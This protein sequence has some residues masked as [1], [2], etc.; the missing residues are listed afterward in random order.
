MGPRSESVLFWLFS[1][2]LLLPT[3]LSRHHAPPSLRTTTLLKDFSSNNIFL[4][5]FTKLTHI[6][7]FIT[8]LDGREIIRKMAVCPS[9]PVA[10]INVITVDAIK[11]KFHVGEREH[12]LVEK[13]PANR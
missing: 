11:K 5:W 2:F 4:G 10:G 12:I 8:G 9:E 1:L 7:L 13:T 6:L 3:L